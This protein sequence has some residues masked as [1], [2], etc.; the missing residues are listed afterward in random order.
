MYT[1]SVCIKT[2]SGVR[3]VLHNQLAGVLG[4]LLCLE[5]NV[6]ELDSAR[7]DLVLKRKQQTDLSNRLAGHDYREYMA[8]IHMEGDK[9]SHLVA[10][11]IQVEK[12]RMAITFIRHPDGHHW[13]K[14]ADITTVFA[15]YYQ[16][17]YSQP[18]PNDTIRVDCFMESPFSG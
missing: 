2:S 9:S 8:H 3:A 12:R 6:V 15:A 17:L 11:L 5:L 16:Q 7:R 14:Q 18:L 1:R 10:G 4:D 13:H